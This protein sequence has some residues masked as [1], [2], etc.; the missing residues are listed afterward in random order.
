MNCSQQLEIK[1]SVA[2]SAMKSANALCSWHRV[3]D[4]K[5]IFYKDRALFPTFTILYFMPFQTPVEPP[6][7]SS[8][9]ESFKT[10]VNYIYSL[11]VNHNNI[12]IQAYQ[13]FLDMIS[14]GSIESIEPEQSMRLWREV[15]EVIWVISVFRNNNI[16]PP[17]ELLIKSFDGKPLDEY[18]ND[19]GRN[20]FLEMRAAIY[21]LRVGYKITLGHECDVIAVRNRDRV[22]IECKRLYSEVKAKDRVRECYEQLEKRLSA[23]DNRYKNLGIAWVDPSPAMQKYFFVY[24]TYS[25]AGA[26]HA[27]RM[28]IAYF[29]KQWIA[30]AYEGKEKRIFALILQMVWPSW[31]AG[32]KKISTGFTSY[33]FPGHSK[34]NFWG[35]WKCRRLL[36]EILSIEEA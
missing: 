14:S 10:A 19:L 7:L 32:T 5:E 15:H 34:I 8:I 22:F 1:F 12:R 23:A 25:E 36:D 21:F 6:P 29:W 9:N 18:K 26:R 33:L 16:K 28:D 11:G 17:T 20:F 31:I 24:T 13:N 3:V 4:F 35:L 30:R 27:A 2:Q